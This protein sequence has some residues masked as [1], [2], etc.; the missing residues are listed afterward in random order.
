V[1]LG[2]TI[3]K[4]NGDPY[5]EAPMTRQTLQAMFTVQVTAVVGGATLTVEVEHR[6]AEDVG[7]AVAALFPPIGAS[8]VF[9][10]QV[11]GLKELVR[12]KHT[13]AGPDSYSGMRVFTPAPQW[14]VD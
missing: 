6:N 13:V 5:V 11:G 3:L 4:M 1:I 8:G 9:S 12:F 2:D 14:L 10:L 7:W